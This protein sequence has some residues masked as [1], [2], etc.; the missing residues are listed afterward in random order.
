MK[1]V[2]TCTLTCVGPG[3]KI[4]YILTP[5]ALSKPVQLRS[6]CWCD[7]I[8]PECNGNQLVCAK[9]MDEILSVPKRVISLFLVWFA[10]PSK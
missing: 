3:W 6:L 2:N 1:R 4:I 8:K 5:P 7:L 9:A 10:A